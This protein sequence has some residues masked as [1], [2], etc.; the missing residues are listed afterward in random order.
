MR[1][2]PLLI[3]SLALVLAAGC[4]GDDEKKAPTT[5]G[6]KTQRSTAGDSKGAEATVRDYLRAL[7][8]KDGGKAC[9]QLTPE[10]Q[11]SVVEQN[12]DFARKAGAED[13]AALIDAV[14]KEA[15]RAT[16]EGRPLNEKTVGKL[17]LKVTVRQ[18]GEEQNAT[19]TGEQGLQRYELYTTGGDWAIAEITQAGG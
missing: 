8:E 4:G 14:T 11:K 12:K 9:S 18:S 10:Y 5:G 6:Q 17:P 13:C 15:P 7:V 16:F 2:L 1:R 3:L 19:V